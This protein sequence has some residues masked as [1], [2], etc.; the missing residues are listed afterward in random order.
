MLINASRQS[1]GRFFLG[2]VSELCSQTNLFNRFTNNSGKDIG[3][4]A[5]KFVYECNKRRILNINIH[6]Q[7]SSFL[8]ENDTFALYWAF[9]VL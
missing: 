1:A 6:L 4:M 9:L 5:V 7:S 2:S 3:D 8:K